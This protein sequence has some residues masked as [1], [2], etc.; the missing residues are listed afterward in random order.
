MPKEV[1]KVKDVG[2]SP[3]PFSH[4]I[5]AGNILYLTSQ[6]SCDLKTGKII[7]GDIT[8]Q[9]KN[10]L[11]NIEYLLHNSGSSIGNIINIIAYIKDIENIDQVYRIISEF[12]SKSTKTAITIIEAS[13]PIKGIDIEIEANALIN[14]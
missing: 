2:A 4:I 7:Y 3:S 14:S 9:T 1:L 6:L 8:L 12:L 13:S 5:K 10:A 11:Y